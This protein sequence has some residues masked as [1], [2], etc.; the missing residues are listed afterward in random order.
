MRREPGVGCGIRRPG[1]L[2]PARRWPVSALPDEPRISCGDLLS[3][4]IILRPLRVK[5]RQ[6]HA[7]VGS[8]Q[9]DS[10]RSGISEAAT[11][12]LEAL[13]PA[14]RLSFLSQWQPAPACSAT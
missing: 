2:S 13:G 3:L 5:R 4:R 8:H 14:P 6:L 11:S 7:R 10:R 12:E 9:N 1:W